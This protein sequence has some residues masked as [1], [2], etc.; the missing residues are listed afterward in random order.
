MIR[1]RSVAI[2]LSV[3]VVLAPSTGLAGPQSLSDTEAKILDKALT[4]IERGKIQEGLAHRFSLSD[5]VARRMLFWRAYSRK[6][7]RGNF[8]TLS[9]FAQSLKAW[10]NSVALRFAAERSID[11]K[12]SDAAILRYADTLAPL[13]YDG[14]RALAG[15]LVKQGKVNEARTLVRRYWR[16][17]HRSAPT[18]INGVFKRFLRPEDHFARAVRFAHR[19]KAGPARKIASA[20]NLS[21]AMRAAI[22]VQLLMHGKS[23]GKSRK[24]IAD[25]VAKL[26]AS[27]RSLPGFQ[28]S[29]AIW[30]R[31]SKQSSLSAARPLMQF[32][33]PISSPAVWWDERDIQIRAAI[34]RRDY[35]LA[36]LMASRHRQR[37]GDRDF[38]QA[39]FMAGFVAL[40]M[41]SRPHAAA[42]HFKQAAADARWSNDRA[43]LAYWQGRAQIALG[44]ALGA[45]PHLEKAAGFGNTIYGQLATALLGRNGIRL[46]K[47][48]PESSETPPFIA[49]NG[50]ARAT[51]YLHQIGRG[52]MARQFALATVREAKLTPKQYAA[53]VAWLSSEAASDSRKRQLEIRLT[54]FAQL[55]GVPLASTGY[56]TISLPAKNTVEPALVYA[57]IRQESEFNPAAKSW[58]GAR[59]YMQLMPFTA[60]D[61]AR[62][63]GYRYSLGRL[64]SAPAYNLRLGTHHLSRLQS[65]FDGAYPL[66][67]AAYNAGAGRSYQW[68]KAYGDPRKEARLDWID[69]IELIPFKE[70]RGYV[71]RVLEA[72]PVYRLQLKDSFVP[73]EIEAYWSA[74]TAEDAAAKDADPACTV[75]L[76]SFSPKKVSITDTYVHRKKY[77][78]KVR[79]RVKQRVRVK[80][81]SG[82]VRVQVRTRTRQVWRTRTRA[83]RK[84]ATVATIAML[85][86]P[87][88]NVAGVL[89]CS[90]TP[91]KK[92][93]ADTSSGDRAKAGQ[94][95]DSPKLRTAARGPEGAVLPALP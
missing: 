68:L 42:H 76:A 24:G 8:A 4:L 15:A 92:A 16:R 5:P 18:A 51:V 83:V 22:D 29:L 17:A 81:K 12:V 87:H 62:I 59:G 23:T 73:R 60:K 95:P 49:D 35:A 89:D 63:V 36:Y 20:L 39:E 77:K 70:T 79:I 1:R 19:R 75:A 27:V 80:T 93:A 71:K 78:V 48:V 94:L 55:K 47:P 53:M 14:V 44:S 65:M 82:K 10:P 52:R 32:P 84:T 66:M 50:L 45:Y 26:P 57:L 85:T 74:D 37:P 72:L 38:V 40:R 91:R 43:R 86:R 58:V 69:W 7:A 56:P 34:A 28:L 25:R 11:S 41:V 33:T 61:E 13:T 3:G 88:D 30:R 2:L 21:K 9:Y 46:K 64:T 54:K 90:D 67:L 31:R 6:G